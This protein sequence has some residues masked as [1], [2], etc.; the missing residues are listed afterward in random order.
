MATWMHFLTNVQ[1]RIS[2]ATGI[3]REAAEEWVGFCQQLKKPLGWVLKWEQKEAEKEKENVVDDE[4]VKRMRRA[5]ELLDSGD[6]VDICRLR[7]R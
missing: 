7:M 3:T 2:S 6:M 5:G 4:F 1:G